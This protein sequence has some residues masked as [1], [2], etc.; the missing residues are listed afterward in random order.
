MKAHRLLGTGS[1]TDLAFERSRSPGQN[2]K[3]KSVKKLK[4]FGVAI[5]LC[6]LGLLPVR[7]RAQAWYQLTSPEGGFSVAV[8]GEPVSEQAS[9]TLEMKN[10]A[11]VKQASYWVHYRE[12]L[13]GIGET[14]ASVFDMEELQLQHDFKLPEMTRRAFAYR[15]HPAC[16]F[17]FTRRLSPGA[18]SRIVRRIVMVNQRVYAVQ[19][20]K[21]VLDFQSPGIPAALKA[22]NFPDEE[23]FFNSLAFSAPSSGESSF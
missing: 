15:G 9:W 22:K 1:S 17:D 11:G 8:P 13:D 3:G 2:R 5:F 18:W 7:G 23:K 14:P 6:G 16:E 4:G 10:R 19:F 20:E 21:L 12:V